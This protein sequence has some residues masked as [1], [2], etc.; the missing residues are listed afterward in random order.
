MPAIRKAA[1]RWLSFMARHLPARSQEWAN[2]MLREAD[3]VE[4]DWRAL[5]WVLGSTTALCR[6]SITL[7]LS[8]L[9]RN[10]REQL[11]AKRVARS[12]FP[13]LSGAAAAL[14]F[15]GVC[16]ASL[17]SLMHAAWFDPLQH[18]L[19]DRMLIVVIPETAY[20]ASTLAL[21]RRRRTFAVGILGAGV[22]LMA[23]AVMH[24]AA[25]A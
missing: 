12:M 17:S 24:F 3:F 2:G 21:W 7:E 13:M 18:R 4:G 5:L 16:I 20:L 23:H 6:Y 11:S 1:S 9:N 25:H 19:A 14:I 15:L 10:R 22:L 8:A